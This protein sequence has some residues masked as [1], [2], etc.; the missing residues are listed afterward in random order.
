[1]EQKIALITGGTSGIGKAT[2]QALLQKGYI[3]Y[4]F[5]RRTRGLPGINHLCV[6][7]TNQGQIDAAVERI[8]GQ[9]GHID[10]V[11]NNAGFGI[12][13]AMEFTDV[14]EAQ[15]LFDVLL[16][17]MM[18]VNHAVLPHLRR[19]GKGRIVN[20]SS[21]AAIAPIPFQTCYSAAKAAVN[22]YT[23]ALANEVRP[24]GIQ[25]CCIQPGDIATGFTAARQKNCA[26][27]D[28]YQGRIGRSVAKMEHDEQTGMSA[29]TAGHFVAHVATRKHVKPIT[30]IGFSYRCVHALIKILP[31]A[32]TNRLIG[33]LYGR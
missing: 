31:A 5:S 25:V 6:D 22:A 26:G 20:L 14:E 24:F 9:A 7:V 33:L 28:V 17:G 29:Q 16:F 11:I 18:R 13:G 15:R 27:D 21:V 1:M 19:A 12:S 2:A 10:V 8:V 30:T 23:M 4:E 32:A 3:V